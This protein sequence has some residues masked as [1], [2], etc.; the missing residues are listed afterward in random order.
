M[1]LDD[2]GGEPL[3]GGA[4]LED[5]LKPAEVDVI[6]RVCSQEHKRNR[7]GD[8]LGYNAALFAQ[9]LTIIGLVVQGKGSLVV[10]SASLVTHC[11]RDGS[12]SMSERG[13][14]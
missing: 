14:G 10:G 4:L 3:I 13:A 12:A 7:G 9:A 6:D 5:L 11:A 2:E 1:E 8:C